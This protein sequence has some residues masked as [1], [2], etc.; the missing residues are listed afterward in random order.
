LLSIQEFPKGCHINA[1][2]AC[3]P[4]ENEITLFDRKH[5]KI[6]LDSYESC[7]IE[8][9]EIIQPLK[10][11][12]LSEKMIIGEL[13]NCIAQKIPGRTSQ[14]DITFFK[15]IGL[16]IEDIYAADFFYKQATNFEIGQWVNI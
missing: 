9:D 12:T 5:L 8:S 7:L 6:Y 14:D 3:R 15:S 10:N 11:H 13:G 4:G 2:G 1:I 16:S